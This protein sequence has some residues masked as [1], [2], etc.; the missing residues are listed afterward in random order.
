[1]QVVHGTLTARQVRPMCVEECEEDTG[2]VFSSYENCLSFPTL[3]LGGQGE[4][5]PGHVKMDLFTTFIQCPG[6]CI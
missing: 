2:I 3:P 4:S 5:R 6:G 1:M